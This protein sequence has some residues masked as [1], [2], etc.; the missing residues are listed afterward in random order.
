[1]WLQLGFLP[2]LCVE[3]LLDDTCSFI[4]K[5]TFLRIGKW[6]EEDIEN[7][8]AKKSSLFDDIYK[9]KVSLWVSQFKLVHG[10]LRCKV[11]SWRHD[12]YTKGTRRERGVNTVSEESN[13]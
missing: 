13:T 6:N 4:V 8:L 2:M 5:L 7:W 12:V 1:M 9:G 11:K 3:T 10:I